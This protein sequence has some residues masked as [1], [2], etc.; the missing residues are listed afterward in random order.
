MNFVE[1]LSLPEILFSHIYK[2]DAYRNRFFAQ[3]FFVEI[4]YIAVGSVVLK[5]GNNMFLAK[6]N[7]VICFLHNAETV[8]SANHFH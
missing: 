8:V 6:K 3:E 7:D 2:S 1:F 4:S 5:I